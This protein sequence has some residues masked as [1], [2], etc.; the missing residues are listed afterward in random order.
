VVFTSADP[1]LI[2]AAGALCP[3]SCV[4]QV[5]VHVR[6][7]DGNG[8][9]DEFG[10]TRTTVVS[11]SPVDGDM[12]AASSP[13]IAPDLST[14]GSVVAFVSKANNLS[15]VHRTV[16]GES[17][18][19]H[20]WT[21]TAGELERIDVIGPN[22]EPVAGVHRDPRLDES[23]RTMVYTTLVAVR[24]G[25]GSSDDAAEIAS[26]E[27]VPA[28][29]EQTRDDASVPTSDAAT[30]D[31]AT[32][33]T[34]SG[35]TPDPG[36]GSG[37]GVAADGTVAPVDDAAESNGSDGTGAD[38]SGDAPVDDQDDAADDDR[39]GDEPDGAEP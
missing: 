4:Q 13:A 37:D 17:S 9:Y 21:W 31:A 7:V 24:A 15:P 35:E 28:D 32:S 1:A 33:D 5:F 38:G 18:D 19:G 39:A 36:E 8:R 10:R 29:E 23:G 6:D 34:T 16:G 3:E 11:A 27:A 20:L 30:S 22:G 12:I 26:D 14:D 25:D 2:E